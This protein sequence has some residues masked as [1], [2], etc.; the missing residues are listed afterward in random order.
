MLTCKYYYNGMEF[1]SELELDDYLLLTKQPKGSDLVLKVGEKPSA[2]SVKSQLLSSQER[3][4]QLKERIKE[5]VTEGGEP[6]DLENITGKKPY[7][8][9][10]DFLHSIMLKNPD[11]TTHPLF[12]IFKP[13]E[14]WPRRK[15]QL[16]NIQEAINNGDVDEYDLA[17]LFK[18]KNPDGSL[19][20]HNLNGTEQDWAEKRMTSIWQQQAGAGTAVHAVFS[21]YFY[22]PKGKARLGNMSPNQRRV[23]IAKQLKEADRKFLGIDR[24]GVQ[25]DSSKPDVFGNILS[26]CGE[27][28]QAI[29]T[30][31][32]KDCEILTE[33]G[34]VGE[35]QVGSSRVPVVGRLDMVVI[36]KDG[37]TNIIDFK[38]TPKKSF[39]SAK[40]LTFNYQLQAYKRLLALNGINTMTSKMYIVPI[41]FKDFNADFDTDEVSFSGIECNQGFFQEL[42]SSSGT[43]SETINDN[44]DLVM[45][46]NQVDDVSTDEIA[47]TVNDFVKTISPNFY[48]GRNVDNQTVT[49]FI[50]QHGGIKEKDGKYY[51]LVTKDAVPIVD[52][53]E[54]RV[55]EQVKMT[56]QG[57]QRRVVES[58]NSIRTTLKEGQ[59]NDA[60]A[61]A[62]QSSGVR[63]LL[64]SKTGSQLWYEKTLGKYAT[65]E[66]EVM[67][68]LPEVFDQYGLILLRN[69]YS[70]LISVV[71][72]TN[73]HPEMK[74]KTGKNTTLLGKYLSDAAARQLPKSLVM[75]STQ[76]NIE[77]MEAMSA[78]NC[79]P[80]FFKGGTNMLGEIMVVN[81][82]LSTGVK[83]SNKELLWNFSK[84]TGFTKTKNNFNYDGSNSEGIKLASYASVARST[85][86]SI[87]RQGEETSLRSN[88]QE[89][90]KFTPELE[91]AVGNPVKMREEL[92]S[93][94]NEM[95]KQFPNIQTK[96][97][98]S[99]QD[100]SQAPEITLMRQILYAI[101]ELN[102][103]DFTQQLVGTAN[104]VQGSLSLKSVTT[105]GINGLRLDNP[106]TSTNQNIN[107][108]AEFTTKAY[109]R[110]RDGMLDFNTE[111][112]KRI[113]I[114]KQEKN[115][116]WGK[117]VT[118]GNQAS[119]YQNLYDP[120]AYEQGE[121][122]FKNPWDPNA[123]LS[124]AER[125]FLMFALHKFAEDRFKATTEEAFQH[126]LD[127]QL[128]QLLQVPLC[129]GSF[130]SSVSSA[131]GF[132]S[133][134]KHKLSKFIPDRS[135]GE[136]LSQI[137]K[138]KAKDELQGFFADEDTEKRV[139]QGEM[140]E[141]TNEFDAGYNADI[142]WKMLENHGVDY[143]EH[144]VE[145][146]LLRHRAAKLLKTEMDKVFPLIK[147]TL[148][149]IGNQAIISND[150]YAD[151]LNYI[152]DYIKNKIFN[153]PLQDV[154]KY[155]GL[156][157]FST[158]LMSNMSKFALA[159]NPHFL[160]QSLDGLWKDV[161]LVIQYGDKE[162]FSKENFTSAAAWVY[163]DLFHFGDSRTL[164]QMLN[165]LYGVN[166]MDI[167][168]LADHYSNDNAGIFNFW[169]LGFRFASRPDYY[170]RMTI[171]GAQMKA[172]GCFDAHKI[173]D[174]KLVYDCKLDKRFDLLFKENADKNSAEY[175]KQLGLYYTMAQ[176][177]IAEG[178]MK[179]EDLDL[180][181]PKPL[182]RAYTNKQAESMKALGDRIYGYYSHEKKSL[183]QATTIGSLFFQMNT[184]W[185]SKKNQ[186]L[187]G[188]GY[189]QQ[190][191]YEQHVEEYVDENGEH[192]SQKYYLKADV[193]GELQPT[194]EETDLPLMVW[195]GD[196]REGIVVTA[197]RVLGSICNGVKNEGLVA[198]FKTGI[199]EIWNEENPELRKLFRANLH[200]L[201]YDLFM[202]LFMGN[203]IA[204]GAVEGAKSHEKDTTN[205]AL[206][207][208]IINNS[209]LFSANMLKSSCDDFNAFESIMG[210]GINWTPFSISQA[211]RLYENWSAALGGSK[212]FYDAMVNSFGASRQA[213][214]LADY[215]KISTTGRKIGES[216][217]EDEE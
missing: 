149:H 74:V 179:P 56:L 12:P 217:K 6:S 42:E 121:F 167:N 30:K 145:K 130:G 66:W 207:N 147:A 206:G 107:K 186:Y 26:V 10:T 9:T 142:R 84:L 97:L 50:A 191:H 170:N 38:C 199:N 95:Q 110:T 53:T 25:L 70:G 181:H 175:K 137:L 4:V 144:N 198:G 18:D 159:W 3:F 158:H 98:N 195:K 22:K 138:Q 73:K 91:Q 203:L 166:D 157:A 113:D 55:F 156:Q 43:L 213:R 32:G 165:E 160:Y 21:A 201:W 85:L 210:R 54:N 99:I 108:I 131:G 96:D 17:Y 87:M 204:A 39:N 100:E 122:K 2:V 35:G 102:N 139:A 82:T 33:I 197:T 27:Y 46:V 169:S 103:V 136:T 189:T 112:Q 168:T 177:F 69:K 104:Y 174:G 16:A 116:G 63:K 133:L 80:N 153:Q 127:N 141:M 172:D 59:K 68:N 7:V 200:Q 15:Q 61:T 182:P 190:G 208:A 126:V 40:I 128:E 173:V 14:Y 176:E 132:I 45:P 212:D 34:V 29:E 36:D 211:T 216:K 71:K 72:I 151:D 90:V 124:P 120:I 60:G 8:G 178:I 214:S 37:N 89:I 150:S 196:P 44:L 93:L 183:I 115:F 5:G 111:L 76:G 23:E 119:I 94:Y 184:Y 205:K 162:A 180:Q 101:A 114:L 24:L 49:D 185:S 51:F 135:K 106:G 164:G 57:R 161:M 192:H 148:I 117:K 88:F 52:D 47:G 48:A 78:L 75:E 163:K 41:R 202:L 134:F 64:H 188:H 58:V 13:E 123:S 215:V 143:F 86:Y 62:F 79:I 129:K 140:F 152:Y 154:D 83:A 171:F 155:G 146:L 109:Q 19:K 11:G 77:L 118:Y 125:D 1:K 105:E 28:S 209:M 187:S 20:V 92:I 194:T 81:P 65:H 31:F 193:N 67:E